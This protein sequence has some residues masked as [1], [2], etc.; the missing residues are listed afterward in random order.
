M[1]I[2]SFGRWEHRPSVEAFFGKQPNISTAA[3]D[4]LNMADDDAD[5]DL[6]KIYEQVT[7]QPWNSDN[8]NPR[9]F[10][11]GFGNAKCARLA[12]A[13]AAKNFEMTWPG[14][15]AVEP[16]YGGMRYEIGYQR[17]HSDIPFGGDGGVGAWAA[18]WLTAGGYGV[19][20]KKA[21]GNIDFTNYSM[22]RCDKYGRSGVPDELEPEAKL[23][24]FKESNLMADAS[25]AWKLMGQLVP[26]VSCSNQGFSMRRNNDGTCTA[27]DTWPHCNLWSGRFTLKNGEQCLR[28]DNH[29]NGKPDGSGYL[30]QP[31]TVEGKNGTIYLNGNQFLVPLDIVDRIVKRGGETY[32]FSGPQGYQVRRPLLL[33]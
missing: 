2:R 13:M 30:G 28:Y 7:G 16:V 31:T 29:W 20:L 15:C 3:F 1:D 18:E 6:C 8:Q 5:V 26:L 4:I 24:P 22:D 32:G 12:M 10:C 17:H 27:N 23:H 33:V 14:D 25:Q 21:Y 11:V 19:L 9:G